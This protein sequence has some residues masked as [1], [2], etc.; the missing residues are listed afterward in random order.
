VDK[1]IE[2]VP[3]VIA[4]LRNLLNAGSLVKEAASAR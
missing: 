4:K 2:I 1:A 3:G